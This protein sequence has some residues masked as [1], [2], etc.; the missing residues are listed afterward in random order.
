[1]VI[2]EMTADECRTALERVSFGRLACAR[3]NQPYVLPIYFSYDGTHLYGFS[4]PGQIYGF[5]TL[6]QKIEW[7]RSN[8]LVCLEIDE[9]TSLHQW[10]SVVVSGRYEE[11]PDTPEFGYERVQAHEVLQ[12]RAMWWE[13]AYV[14]TEHRE[15]LTPI[16]YRIHITQMTGRRATPDPVEA[17]ASGAKAPTAEE[18]WLGSILHHWNRA[19]TFVIF[20]P[21]QTTTEALIKLPQTDQTDALLRNSGLDFSYDRLGGRYRLR[22]GKDEIERSSNL[23]TELMKKA[24]RAGAE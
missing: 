19:T 5:S 3:D 1:M 7:L 2:H 14:V 8:P 15:Q 22:L 17:A 12:K 9:R 13:P 10:M 20:E 18:S 4:A 23:L 11:L 6:G 16:F 24:Q 21:Q